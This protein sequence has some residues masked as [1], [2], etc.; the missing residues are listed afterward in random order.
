MTGHAEDGTGPSRAVR[1]LLVD[2]QALVR[3]GLR[4]VLESEPGF[5]V[6]GEAADGLQAVTMCRALRPDVVL[7]DVRMPRSSGLEATAR[8]VE[9]VPESRVVILTT[10]DLDEY[11]YEGLRAGASGFLLKDTEPAEMLAAVRAVAAGEAV[12]APRVTRRLLQRFSALLPDVPAEPDGEQR[13]H[14]RL[15]GLTDRE[16]DVLT[17]IASGLSNA[18]IAEDLA[19]SQATVKTHVANILAKL[20]VRDRVQAV[21][22][23]F[24]TRLVSL[25]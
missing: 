21:I 15:S 19:L 18:E 4:L 20:G 14:P 8:I 22:V 11:V 1:L 2:D 12:I 3:M 24:E 16:L 6:V 7:L 23:A 17:R 9:E 25:S 13:L 5:E 10:F